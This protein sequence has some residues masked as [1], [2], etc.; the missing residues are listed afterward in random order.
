MKMDT[1]NV[2][3][4]IDGNISVIPTN[5]FYEEIDEDEFQNVHFEVV[6][7]NRH[8]QSKLSDSV[9][10]AVKY[11]QKELP[12][13]IAI[14]CCQS[15]RYGNFNPY[16]N[17]ENEIFCLKDK[18]PQSRWDVVEIFSEPNASFHERSRKLL[19]ICMDYKPISNDE[20]Y[21]YNDWEEGLEKG[22]SSEIEK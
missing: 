14:A 9:E 7:N 2:H 12:D 13:N 4:V 18:T 3:Y 20:I 16:G 6:V 15:C 1:V 17:M 8:I 5:M 22:L 10:Y 19:D 21:T 11:L